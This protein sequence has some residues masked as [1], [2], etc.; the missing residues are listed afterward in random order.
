MVHWASGRLQCTPLSQFARNGELYR[1]TYPNWACQCYVPASST[2]RP[3]VQAEQLLEPRADEDTAKQANSAYRRGHWSPRWSQAEDLEFCLEM[4]TGSPLPWE[5]HSRT[6]L[7]TTLVEAL[8]CLLRGPRRPAHVFGNPSAHVPGG[9]AAA[10]APA[11]AAPAVHQQPLWSTSSSSGGRGHA[12]PARE[13][14]AA[15]VRE[16]EAYQHERYVGYDQ[17]HGHDQHNGWSSQ[18]CG[19]SPWPVQPPVHMGQRPHWQPA[20]LAGG[21]KNAGSTLSADAQVFIPGQAPRDWD[22]I[23]Q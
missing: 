16:V 2:S 18:G 6:T 3:H 20:H 5:V 8:G 21:G 9:A 14:H 23:Y 17:S 4:K 7:S 15:A 13:P 11:P 10:A 19:C 12:P 22:G 1:V